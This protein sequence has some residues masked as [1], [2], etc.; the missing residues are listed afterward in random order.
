V[1]DAGVNCGI[2]M[3]AKILQRALGQ[4]DDG[5][6]GT[7]TLAAVNAAD[8]AA[9]ITA[10]KV[11]RDTYY[12]ACQTFK[13]HGPAWLKRS[14]A[15]HTLQ[16]AMIAPA[17]APWP[18]ADVVVDFAEHSRPATPPTAVASVAETSTG[19][20]QTAQIALGSGVSIAQGLEMAERVDRLGMLQTL[21]QSP[22]MLAV[23]VG[24]IIIA[25]GGVW[26]LR[27]RARKLILGV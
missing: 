15:S 22:I 21:L 17:A 4:K 12:R 14:A 19:T 25:M 3:G 10:F 7:V 16:L 6:I 2:G 18:A 26:Q 11:H 8:L 24:G 9:T 1:F 20:V 5:H 27:D 23:I 13:Y